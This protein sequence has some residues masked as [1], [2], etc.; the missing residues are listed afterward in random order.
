MKLSCDLF[1]HCPNSFCSPPALNRALWGTSFLKKSSPNHP[2]KGL[3]PPKIKEMP[4]FTKK[5]PQTIQ[6]RVETP[7]P[8][9]PC[10]EVT[11]YIFGFPEGGCLAAQQ[12]VF[13]HQ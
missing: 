13:R 12:R 5:V 11:S 6:A 4:N 7:F 8:N 2:G 9:I 3:D 1:G 10:I